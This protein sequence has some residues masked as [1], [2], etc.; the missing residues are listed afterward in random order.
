MFGALKVI[1]FHVV[2]MVVIKIWN[3]HSA[4][5]TIIFCPQNNR[6]IYTIFGKC[7]HQSAHSCQNRI[8]LCEIKSVVGKDPIVSILTLIEQ[9]YVFVNFETIDSHSYFS[10][11]LQTV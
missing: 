9:F 4:F 10:A 6:N 8:K 11:N 2:S 7:N 3:E 5:F 1:G